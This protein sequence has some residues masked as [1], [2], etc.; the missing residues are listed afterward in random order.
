MILKAVLNVIIYKESAEIIS[1]PVELFD[2]EHGK[3]I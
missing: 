2:E 3:K 1:I